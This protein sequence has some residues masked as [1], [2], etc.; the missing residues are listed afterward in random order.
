MICAVVS[1]HT[2]RLAF[3]SM[4]GKQNATDFLPIEEAARQVGL[5]HWT[6]RVWLHKRRLTRYKS[7]SRTVVSRLELLELLKPT[8]AKA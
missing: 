8:K 1:W 3:L 2:L 6:I 7:G 5:S 4:E